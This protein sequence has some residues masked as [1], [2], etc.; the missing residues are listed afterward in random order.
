MQQVEGDR[1][2]TLKF[3][4]L[5]FSVTAVSKLTFEDNFGFN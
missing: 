2:E 1:F 4:T 5:L 3:H